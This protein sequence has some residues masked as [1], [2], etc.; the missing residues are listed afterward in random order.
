MSVQ[1]RKYDSDN[2]ID[3]Y[4]GF[5]WLDY[6][7]KNRYPCDTILQNVRHVRCK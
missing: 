3:D 5:A 6:S 7:Q 1:R 2:P 4:S